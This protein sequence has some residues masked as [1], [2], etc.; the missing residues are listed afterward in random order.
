MLLAVIAVV[1]MAMNKR[2]P[3]ALSAP[4]PIP[5]V[6]VALPANTVVKTKGLPTGSNGNPA[7]ALGSAPSPGLNA[8]TPGGLAPAAGGAAPTRAKP[9]MAAS[10]S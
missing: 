3:V 9:S 10:G 5:P 1:V 8:P 4:E 6:A 2:V 7:G